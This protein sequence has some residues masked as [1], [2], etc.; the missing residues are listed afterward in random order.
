MIPGLCDGQD[1]SKD[2]IENLFSGVS[3]ARSYA[4]AASN[5]PRKNRK[6]IMPAQFWAA[7]CNVA[8]MPLM[9]ALPQHRFRSS[10]GSLYL[11]SEN[12]DGTNNMGREDLPEEQRKLKDNV[13]NVEHGQKPVV[14]ISDKVK[15]LFHACNLC[16]TNI[17][18]VQESEQIW[19]PRSSNFFSRFVGQ[20]TY[21]RRKTGASN[22]NP[23]F[24]EREL[25]HLDRL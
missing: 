22:A 7:A 5:A 25:R 19:A 9:K 1:V 2:A 14:S 3:W 23:A 8:M 6:A 12:N 24:Y 15:V 20:F 21:T 18:T 16:I 4:Y 17:A 10:W 13:R 11:P